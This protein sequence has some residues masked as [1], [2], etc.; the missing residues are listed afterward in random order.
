MLQFSARDYC[1][2]LS[3][4]GCMIFLLIATR[5]LDKGFL[6]E[7]P[8]ADYTACFFTVVS[9]NCLSFTNL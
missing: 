6:C 1:R 2:W 5:Y 8:L 4:G 7:L 3:R 9:R